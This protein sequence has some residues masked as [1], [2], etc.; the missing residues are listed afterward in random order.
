MSTRRRA[1]PTTEP[2][3]PAAEVV[4]ERAEP[5]RRPAPAPLS[6]EAIVRAALALADAEGLEAVSLRRVGGALG[7]GP[8]RLYGY[9]STKEELLDLLVDAVYGE[10][11]A[12]RAMRGDWRKVLRGLARGLRRTADTHPWFVAL[13][14]GRPHLGPN[15][16]AYL[17][18]TLGALDDAGTFGHV[19]AIMQA[20]QTV[21]AYVIG[22]IQTEAQE[23]V[24]QALSGKSK[25]EWQAAHAPYIQRLLATGRF[26][27]LAR[28]LRNA[29][30]PPF[31]VVFERG[32]GCVL[33]GIAAQQAAAKRAR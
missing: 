24:A 21:N 22:A 8:M 28:V 31:D 18:S 25:S 19:D 23:R 32:L 5:T 2:A 33:D 29:T 12:G 3:P 27:A 13:L 10:M 6:R 14:G 17:E 16:L 11:A 7:A 4:W 9:V 30:H 20:V 26:P 15:A 1:T